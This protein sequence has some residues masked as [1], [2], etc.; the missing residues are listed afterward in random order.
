M[1]N[2]IHSTAVVH[3]SA[4]IGRGNWIGPFCVIGPHAVIGNNNLLESHVCISSPPE[5]REYFREYGYGVEIGDENIFRE[6]VTAN[7]G[8][9]RKTVIGN[10]NTM[11][12]GSHAG[13]DCIIEDSVT[14]SC[15]VMLGGFTHVMRGANIGLGA[16]IH[17]N[18][19]IGSYS[20]TGM[21]SVVTKNAE[22]AP[23]KKYAGN[24]VRILGP[25]VV[26]LERNNVD[27]EMLK[28]ETL[29]FFNLRGR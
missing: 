5:H 29:R 25:N 22:I 7:S 9:L 24:P 23:G 8:S 28:S 18:Q 12:R 20:I 19:V 6:F 2:K 16:V 14:V 17:Q 21:A 13:H 3:P 11:L 27:A 1:S 4:N 26:G 10:K 15:S